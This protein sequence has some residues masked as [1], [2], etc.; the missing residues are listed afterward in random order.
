MGHHAAPFRNW[1]FVN[2]QIL[3]IL[4]LSGSKCFQE[5]LVYKAQITNKSSKS[6]QSFSPGRMTEIHPHS[7]DEGPMDIGHKMSM[8]LDKR[9]SNFRSL[10]VL[11]FHICFIVTLCYKMRQFLKKRQDFITKCHSYYKIRRLLQNV[12]VHPTHLS[13]SGIYKV[14]FREHVSVAAIRKQQFRNLPIHT[15]VLIAILN[16]SAFVASTQF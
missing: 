14:K 7:Q 5:N 1:N 10:Q 8:V 13:S 15:T 2:Q 6:S 12:S 11:W 3:L 9:K 16:P 4:N